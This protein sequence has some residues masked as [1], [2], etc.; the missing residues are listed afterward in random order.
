M[1]NTLHRYGSPESAA[2]D[3]IVFTLT[4]KGINDEG[5]DAK[6][7]LFLQAALRFNPVNMASGHNGGLARPNKKLNLFTA[8]LFSRKHAVTPAEVIAEAGLPGHGTVVFD[9]K[10]AFEGFVAEVK[11]LD[12]GLSVNASALVEDTRCACQKA[13]FHPHSVE[14]S[15]GFHGRTDRLPDGRILELTTMCGHGMVSS[16]FAQKMLLMVK[17]GRVSPERASQYMSKF[18]TCGVFNPSRATRVLREGRDG[19][20]V[21]RGV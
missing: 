7:R 11:K 20:T 13:G 9:N 15:L 3:Y 19:L 2:D 18:C 21:G 16:A 5:S 6:A 14:Y 17:E 12:L 10:A 8:Y 1:T 4:S